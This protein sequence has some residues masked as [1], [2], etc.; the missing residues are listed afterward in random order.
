MWHWQ[1]NVPYKSNQATRRRFFHLAAT[2]LARELA[3]NDGFWRRNASEVASALRWALDGLIASDNAARLG[4]ALGVTTGA[5]VG[6]GSSIHNQ[7]M[8]MVLFPSN[9]CRPLPIS[10]GLGWS[11]CMS[12]VLSLFGM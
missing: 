7:W 9:L 4:G 1:V 2:F 10:P 11:L 5:D 6:L 12:G 8:Y 3:L